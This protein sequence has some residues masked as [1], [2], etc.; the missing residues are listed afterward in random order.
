LLADA[1]YRTL[2]V[3]PHGL[4][5]FQLESMTELFSYANFVGLAPEVVG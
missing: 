5:E 2:L 1:G 4:R 3:T